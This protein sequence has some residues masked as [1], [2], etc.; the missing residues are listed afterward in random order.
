VLEL[1]DALGDVID[2]ME[3]NLK[4]RWWWRLLWPILLYSPL[5][6]IGFYLYNR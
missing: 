4:R 6:I 3:E 5:I 2:E 1:T